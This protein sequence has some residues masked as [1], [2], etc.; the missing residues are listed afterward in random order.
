MLPFS[1][2]G[3]CRVGHCCPGCV[4][5]L[6]LFRTGLWGESV[7]N[8]ILKNELERTSVRWE[9]AFEMR[10]MLPIQQYHMLADS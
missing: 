4:T 10:V 2:L 3:W 5:D 7:I 9:K 1:L 8:L 6:V